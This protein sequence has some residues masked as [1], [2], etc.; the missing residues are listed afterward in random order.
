MSECAV[1]F[2]PTQEQTKCHHSVCHACIYKWA[3]ARPDKSVSCPIC[4]VVLSQPIVPVS[5]PPEVKE[6]ERDEETRKWLEENAHR[7]PGC[8]VWTDRSGGCYHVTCTRCNTSFGHYPGKARRL[9]LGVLLLRVFLSWFV[10][11]Y[12]QISS[13]QFV[14]LFGAEGFLIRLILWSLGPPCVFSEFLFTIH[15]TVRMWFFLLL[16]RDIPLSIHPL[17]YLAGYFLLSWQL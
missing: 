3:D 16:T 17:L 7:C 12:L 6:G 10:L 11:G 5:I 15:L 13:W 2:L 1:C 4:R 8:N 14:L 9:N